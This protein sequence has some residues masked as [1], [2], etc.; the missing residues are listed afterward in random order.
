[1]LL[2]FAIGQLEAQVTIGS[3][4]S[5]LE[6]TLLDL[7]EKNAID[8]G[9]TSAKGLGLPRVELTAKKQL[10][11]MF[12]ATD[13]LYNTEEKKKSQ[14]LAHIGM[15]VYATEVFEMVNCPGIYVWTGEEWQYLL[16]QEKK[17]VLTFADGEGNVYTYKQYGNLY[18]MTQNV[19]SLTLGGKGVNPLPKMQYGSKTYSP[20]A[21]ELKV[22]GS[23]K[24]TNFVEIASKNDIA[25]QMDI[26]YISNGLPITETFDEYLNKFGLLYSYTQAIE[27]CPEGWRL[28]TLQEWKDLEKSIGVMLGVGA[29]EGHYDVY[30]AMR[31]PAESF[32]VIGD[33]PL[34]WG[35]YDVCAEPEKGVGFDAIPV[36]ACTSIPEVWMFG[37]GAYFWTSSFDSE[38][39]VWRVG[40]RD[41]AYANDRKVNYTSYLTTAAN[42]TLRCVKAVD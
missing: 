10:Y 7:K 25:N 19:R 33:S 5:P 11:P 34:S 16:T 4:E 15:I 6:G 2:V 30:K 29:V 9:V 26:S 14:D 8:D 40:I 41:E 22:Q 42:Y 32:G 36:G 28:P 24:N 17:E 1:M 27:A 21:N 18:W 3:A 38:G 37:Y 12:S 31:Y 35:G 23:T 39:K 13:E 20:I